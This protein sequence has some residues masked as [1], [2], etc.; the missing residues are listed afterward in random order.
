MTI[1]LLSIASSGAGATSFNGGLKQT[2][3]P[4]TGAPGM[5][6]FINFIKGA[7]VLLWDNIPTDPTY[8]PFGSEVFMPV[9]ANGYPTSIP[10]GAV[11]FGTNFTIPNATQYAGKWV[12]KW[13]GTGTAG[14][15][16]F[17]FTAGPGFSGI[18]SS[19]GRFE[20]FNNDTSTQWTSAAFFC[21][22]TAASP[23]HLKN[24]RLCRSIDEAAMDAGQLVFHDHLTLMRSAK[25]GA[26]RSLGWGGESDGTNT[27]L[28]GLW[29]QRRPV[30][31]VNYR[32]YYF[33]PNLYGGVTTHSG[34]DYSLTYAGFTLTDKALIHLIWDASAP[35]R[36]SQN[37]TV[38][39]STTNGNPIV[40]NRTSHGLSVGNTVCF[41]NSGLPAGIVVSQ[42]YFV[43]N[44]I[45]ANNFNISATSGGASINASAT[46]SGSWTIAQMPRLAINGGS[47]INLTDFQTPN[48]T[49]IG[50]ICGV[51]PSAGLSTIIYDQ[52]TNWWHIS[53]TGPG[54]MVGGPPEVFVDYCAAIGAN[55][56]ITAPFMTQTTGGALGGVTD[57]MPNWV[58]YAKVT[59]SWMKPLVEPYNETWNGALAGLGTQYAQTLAYTLWPTL[60]GTSTLNRAVDNSYGKWVSDLGQAI[61]AIYGNDRTKY[62]ML[63]MGQGVTWHDAASVNINDSRLV[64][65]LYVTVNGGQPAYKF[66][67]R[68][69]AANYIGSSEQDGLQEQIDS[70]NYYVT[71]NGNSSGQ[72]AISEA[73]TAN[74]NSGVDTPYTTTYVQTIFINIKAWALGQNGTSVVPA[75]G[76]SGNTVAGIVGYEGGWGPDVPVDHGDAVTNVSLVAT[77]G[78]TQANPCVVTLASGNST[79]NVD[80]SNFSGN[81][82]VVG[83]MV[84][85]QFISGMTQLNNGGLLGATFTNGSA[86]ITCTQTL[87]A[88]QA[89]VF[90]ADGANPPSPFQVNIPYHVLSTGLSGSAF[91]LSATKGG[92]AIVALANQ[93][94]TVFAQGGWFITATGVST[95]TLDVDSTGFTAWTNASQAQIIWTQTRVY[96]GALRL[97]GLTTNALGTANTQMYANH[98]ALSGS[99]FTAEYPSNFIY[100]GN[101]GA[102]AVLNPNIYVPLTAQWNSIVAQQ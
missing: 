80:G 88:N 94:T 10:T 22:A 29:S 30:G 17:A 81:P 77:P 63:S 2:G 27:S 8:S 58:T 99:G 67:D 31:Y 76:V 40:V 20:F 87:I 98:L 71:N 66:C 93:P 84:N 55:P 69:G 21:S 35:N 85:M 14:M 90:T 1:G 97:S 100:F 24:L 70:V 72:S 43:S 45:D 86:S 59:Y 26:I 53:R 52:T 65:N 95:I 41:G 3:N 13:D 37:V 73:Y 33:N 28:I 75:P 48:P 79:T 23:N 51:S 39:W 57:Y 101:A 78:I 36:Q 19:T 11:N 91:Q 56:W 7:A 32:G 9:D 62:S 16:N 38:A 25:P 6:I 5:Y 18:S 54:L 49:N 44:V 92:S 34:T 46:T 12:L 74:A 15:R 68:V 47:F 61:S 96:V 102:W 89:V 42:Q 83:Q 4:N 50:S 60:A 64:S 82:G